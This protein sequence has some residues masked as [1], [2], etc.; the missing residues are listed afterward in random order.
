MTLICSKLC[1]FFIFYAPSVELWKRNR[2][3]HRF[4]VVR[5]R[6]LA[7][8]LTHCLLIINQARHWNRSL[9]GIGRWA[10]PKIHP[11]PTHFLCRQRTPS[12]SKVRE[13]KISNSLL[14][15]SGSVWMF[16]YLVFNRGRILFTSHPHG[17]KKRKIGRKKKEALLLIKEYMKICRGKQRHKDEVLNN[18]VRL[19]SA[20]SAELVSRYT[21]LNDT[22]DVKA[23]CF[24]RYRAIL[25][26]LI[27]GRSLQCQ[28]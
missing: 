12:S 3:R 18:G 25:C 10:H 21:C 1:F 15:S 26:H 5:S 8:S 6:S 4:A 28:I 9:R 13:S 20:G 23:C 11:Q 7:L 19:R 2:H 22:N 27:H 14:I 24:A 16:L 17:D